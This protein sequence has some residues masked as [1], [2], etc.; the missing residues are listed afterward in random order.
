MKNLSIVGV[1]VG[2]LFVT[3]I[4]GCTNQD[5]PDADSE[6]PTAA[7]APTGFGSPRSGES[8]VL[9]YQTPNPRQ[10]AMLAP[11][12]GVLRL[13]DGGCLGLEVEGQD[14]LTTLLWPSSVS[15]GVDDDLLVVLDDKG[16]TVARQDEPLT[17]FGGFVTSGQ[18]ENQ[19][20]ILSAGAPVF[21]V[22]T[23]P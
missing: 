11:L 19:P 4:A 22:D 5:Q 20:C 21:Q 17:V 7:S 14:V 18:Y 23:I 2:V 15:S 6:L 9:A 16:A 1:V 8:E 13:A 3:P 10:S 12:D